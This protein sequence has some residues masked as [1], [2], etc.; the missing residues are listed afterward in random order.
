M[1]D[2][3]VMIRNNYLH[4]PLILRQTSDI[5]SRTVSTSEPVFIDNFMII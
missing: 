5:V 3:Q 4:R 1:G 2:K